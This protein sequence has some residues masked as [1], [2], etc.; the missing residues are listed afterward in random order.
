MFYILNETQKLLVS[1]R[2]S[3]EIFME[4]ENIEPPKDQ[5]IVVSGIAANALKKEQENLRKN[6]VRMSL[7]AI[8]SKAITDQLK[9][10]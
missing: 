1:L 6:G 4:Q 8:A 7:G 3:K 5:A 9:G 10:D 2:I